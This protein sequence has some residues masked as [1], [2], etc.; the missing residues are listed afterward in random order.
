MHSRAVILPTGIAD[1]DGVGLSSFAP[2][3]GLH[4]LGQTG[5]SRSSVSVHALGHNQHVLHAFLLLRTAVLLAG[6]LVR[7][8][9]DRAELF[10]ST[11]E[12]LVNL[13]IHLLQ[14]ISNVSV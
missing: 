11:G 13:V 5:M 4:I 7:V 3:Q 12:A 14:V 10:R 1:T 8:Q 6:G 9:N 2:L